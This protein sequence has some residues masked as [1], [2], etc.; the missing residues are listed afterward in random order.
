MA[1]FIVSL[2]AL[3]L[4]TV[5]V[6]YQTTETGSAVAGV[7]FFASSGTVTFLPGETQSRITITHEGDTSDESDENYSVSLTA[8]VN[9][10]LS[11]EGPVLSATGVILDDESSA[12]DLALFVSDPEIYET[13]SGQVEAIFEVTLSSPS[14]SDITLNYATSNGTALAGQDYTS[15]SGTLTFLAGQT[16][17]AV[18][19]PVL[20]DR[21]I[22]TA[23]EFS[24]V[25]TPNGFIQNGTQDSTGTAR[26]LNDDTRFFEGGEGND[27]LTGTPE[28]DTLEGNGGDDLI[29]GLGND[30]A[31]LSAMV[32]VLKGQ[33]ALIL[34]HQTS[35]FSDSVTLR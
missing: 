33:M 28:N 10:V 19:V 4:Q 6:E 25:V 23:E 11:G 15:T 17:A 24:L 34:W 8:P 18:K 9:A 31:L 13:N 27:T 21:T 30:K 29:T 5:T 16:V 32:L 1:D 2:S 12:N 14:E 3:S 35:N 20:G 22:E 26:I 7:D